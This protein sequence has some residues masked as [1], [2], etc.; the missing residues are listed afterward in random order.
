MATD[1]LIQHHP[2]C[3]II[4]IVTVSSKFVTI[5]AFETLIQYYILK[6]ST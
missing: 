5:P 1:S 6:K 4:F 2:V 3:L